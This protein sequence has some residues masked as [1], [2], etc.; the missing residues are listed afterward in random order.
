[1]KNFFI[2]LVIIGYSASACAQFKAVDSIKW[3]QQV[4]VNNVP[5]FT[6][7]G[8]VPEAGGTSGRKHGYYGSQYARLLQLK[9]GTWLA[10]YTVSRNNGYKN[11]PKGGLELEVA[12]SKDNCRT[13]K[14]ISTITDTGRD[15]DNAQ[16]VELPD[17]TILLACRSVR[18]QESYV[19]PVY[20]STDKGKSWKR[21]SIIDE[22]HGKPG[23]LGKPDKGIY[24]PHFYFLND[25][26]LSVMYANEKHVV[27]TPSYS[28]IIS[29]KISPDMGKTWGK[30]IWVAYEPGHNASRPGM[31]VWTKMNNGKYIV[32]YE[33]CGPESCNIYNKI[34][35]DGINWPVGLGNL[36][37]DQLGGPYILSLKSG[38]LVVTSNKSQVSVSNDYGATWKTVNPAWPKTLWPS[39]Y[40]ISDNEIGVVNSAFRA[41]G[42]NNIQIR[43]GKID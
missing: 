23:D 41:E 13:W 26:R 32:V 37:P 40:Q 12:V 11:D 1:M 24:E 7:A 20:K 42:G 25:G 17:G 9:N 43:L 8:K 22:T 36:I 3:E 34:S 10:G 16:L 27:E 30:E 15:L 33:I 28:Q 38:A 29:Q 2:L 18:W 14:A 35:D 5:V 19:L 6:D 21:L 4:L 39:V 31:S